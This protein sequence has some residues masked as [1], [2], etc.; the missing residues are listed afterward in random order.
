[1]NS[2]AR[3]L[4]VT[5]DRRATIEW[6]CDGRELERSAPTVLQ[7]GAPETSRMA[8]DLYRCLWLQV[9]AE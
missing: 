8:K 9:N 5:F 6:S 7:I 1:L 4:D 3:H 2:S